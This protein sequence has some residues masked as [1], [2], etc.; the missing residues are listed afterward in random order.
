MTERR[1][2]VLST[3]PAG[4]TV[5]QLQAAS[6]SAADHVSRRIENS[7]PFE[8]GRTSG[9]HGEG[10]RAPLA[11]RRGPAGRGGY[12]ATDEDLL[13]RTL[14]FSGSY[15][16]DDGNVTVR[17]IAVPTIEY[18]GP[19]FVAHCSIC[20]RAGLVPLTGEPLSDVRAA[21]LFVAAH[22]HGESD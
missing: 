11:P 10:S 15:V 14:A 7:G 9:G 4:R 19:R 13:E 6:Q 1:M 16:S 2:K 17:R 22:D 20:S 12:M 8:T 21:I 3:R 5:P 18:S